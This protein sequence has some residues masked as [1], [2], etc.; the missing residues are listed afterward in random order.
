MENIL[1]NM[2]VVSFKL[3]V[4]IWVPSE[5]DPDQRFIA[6]RLGINPRRRQEGDGEW[7]LASSRSQGN[8]LAGDWV[9]ASRGQCSAQ[10]RTTEELRNLGCSK[11]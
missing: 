1:A 10:L 8:A 5:A 11:H 2:K 6:K 9:S 7:G 3:S 4:F